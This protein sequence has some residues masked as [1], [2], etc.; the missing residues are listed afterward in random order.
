MNSLS[1]LAALKSLS[2]PIHWAM[3]FFDGVHVGHRRI[4][5]STATPGS[6]RGV[7]TFAPHPAAV[8][9][10]ERAPL[11][12]TPD[13]AYKAQLLQEAG[14]D[15]LLTLPF[16]RELAATPAPDFLEQ[17]HS[18]CPIAG[19]SVGTNWRFG[20]GGTGTPELLRA[21]ADARGIR[22]CVH[23]LATL[24]EEIICSTRIRQLV[25]AGQMDT[26]ATMLGRSFCIPG[27][28]EHGQQLA[29]QLGFPTANIPI[30]QGMALPP[31][32]VYAVRCCVGGVAYQG[33]A[34]LGLRPTVD[35]TTT[36][37]LEVHLCGF[38]GNLY[39]LRL[40]TELLRFI[41]PERRFDS[42]DALKAQIQRDLA[43][44]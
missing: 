27:V 21:F 7:L 43:A 42:I 31:Y 23:E 19:V 20:K 22:T 11:L 17:L 12:L 2:Q 39:G 36:P 41:R 35:N 9:A 29:R 38:Q 24:G 30:S 25:A 33:I 5:A 37:R 40:H 34:N 32:G 3:G 18:A 8:L 14:V 28:V 10:P 4:I 13:A 26:A 16:T 6:L 1:S 44:L 15:V